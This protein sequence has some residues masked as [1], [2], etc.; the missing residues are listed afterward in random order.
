MLFVADLERADAGLVDQPGLQVRD[1]A[2]RLVAQPAH[3]VEF[4]I[5]ARAHEAAIAL[6]QRHLIVE[7]PFEMV[8]EGRGESLDAGQCVGH[9]FGDARV[10]KQRSDLGS[11]RHAGAQRAE[12]ARAA[13]VE[14][15]PRERARHVR[16]AFQHAAKSVAQGRFVSE[17][18]D[19]IESASDLAGIG[20]G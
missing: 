17:E 1:D 15:Q 5:V 3:L 7:G 19:G 9:L 16:S 12:V 11:R 13:A 2:A 8:A 6:E 14:R 10:G 20:R 4:G 18:G